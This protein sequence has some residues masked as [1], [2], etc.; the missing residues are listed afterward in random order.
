MFLIFSSIGFA[1][2]ICPCVEFSSRRTLRGSSP[3]IKRIAEI[4]RGLDTP[5]YSDNVLIGVETPRDLPEQA[6]EVFRG[7]ENSVSNVNAW[8]FWRILGVVG[9]VPT[10]TGRWHGLGG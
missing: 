4:L 8:C 6:I 7:F 5:E 2:E 3:C 10:L 1:R 9:W